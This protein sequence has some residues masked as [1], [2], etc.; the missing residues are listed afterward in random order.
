M[1]VFTASRKD[2]RLLTPDNFK[3]VGVPMLIS[4]NAKFA[5]RHF[6]NQHYPEVA[7]YTDFSPSPIPE[8]NLKNP[9]HQR[10]LERGCHLLFHRSGGAGDI[11]MIAPLIESLKRVYPKTEVTFACD[12]KYQGVLRLLPCIDSVTSLPLTPDVYKNFDAHVSFYESIEI[13]SA[14]ARETHG[15]DL[16]AEH[17][18]WEWREGDSKIPAISIPKRAHKKIDKLFKKHKV[19]TDDAILVVQFM[20]SNINRA[21]DVNKMSQVVGALAG[22]PNT[23]IFIVG[24]NPAECPF[25]WRLESGESVKCIHKVLGDL[26]WEETAA[27][28]SRA[29]LCVAPDSAIVH[30]AGCQ[31]KPCIGLYGP[32]PAEIRT[33]YYPRTIAVE[34]TAECAPCFAHG[35]F[36][37]SALT[38][39]KKELSEA[40]EENLTL[41][42]AP[43]WDPIPVDSL[44]SLIE[45]NLGFSGLS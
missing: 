33:K 42:P 13:P 11:L 25:D 45:T 23:H 40:D 27:L 3:Y 41:V 20:S 1:I 19:K 6:I 14:R 21:F 36:P 10:M 8:L 35:S 30:I 12:P 17:I 31:D 37:C 29:S 32:F 7:K 18:H 43:C 28:V 22:R 34:S 15:V 24:G 9:E 38:Q 4:D 26:T 5:I 39:R 44:V 16:F 2:P